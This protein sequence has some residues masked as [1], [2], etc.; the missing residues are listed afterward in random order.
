MR[1]LTVCPARTATTPSCGGAGADLLDGGAGFDLASYSDSSHGVTVEPGHG[2][3]QRRHRQRRH[4][5]PRSR[6]STGSAHADTLIGNDAANTFRGGAGND[7]LRGGEGRIPSTAARASTSPAISTA[8]VGVT[9]N[10][11][12]GTGSGGTA[13]GDTL[14]SIEARHRLG[15]CRHA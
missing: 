11:A 10:L 9:V 15:L 7:V 8:A 2:H 3:R 1:A 6:P 14:V 5:W 13:N 12:A 4:A